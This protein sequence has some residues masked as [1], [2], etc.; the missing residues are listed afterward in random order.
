MTGVS[1][2]TT[3]VLFMK[4]ETAAALMVI[5]NMPIS[6][7]P[8]AVMQPRLTLMD[9]LR[10]ARDEDAPLGAS[11][12]AGPMEGQPT[13]CSDMELYMRLTTLDAWQC[14]QFDPRVR[15]VVPC[16][17]EE[18]YMVHKMD[19]GPYCMLAQNMPSQP[20]PLGKPVD[21]AERELLEGLQIHAGRSTQQ[22]RPAKGPGKISP[23][24]GWTRARGRGGRS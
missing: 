10:L 1:I 20:M 19:G 8:A 3:G 6:G 24:R 11:Y 7:E 23:G 17:P 15:Y 22:R 13:G 4:A 16:K 21:P 12:Y 2:T 9:A 5:V 18:S 14:E